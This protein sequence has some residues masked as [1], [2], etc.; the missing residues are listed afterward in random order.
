MKVQSCIP[1][2]HQEAIMS[3]QSD[4]PSTVLC[5]RKTHE[6]H[7]S[8]AGSLGLD[9]QGH[10]AMQVKEKWMLLWATEILD[11]V[12]T[13]LMMADN[14]PD[15]KAGD[16]TKCFFMVWYK[17]TPTCSTLSMIGDIGCR[18]TS[19][20]LETMSQHI[21]HQL[22]CWRLHISQLQWQSSPSPWSKLSWH[23]SLPVLPD[24]L[25]DIINNPHSP[26]SWG[27][28]WNVT[29][30]S[31]FVLSDGYSQLWLCPRL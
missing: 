2:I 25:L 4:I 16:C 6:V 31:C 20:T 26:Y 14:V 7:L 28:T 1:V 29:K 23:F 22:K 15:K 18:N 10:C 13:K 30:T 12:T 8:P 19:F 27:L 9:L 11:V 3:P 24:P 17:T 5:N 21:L